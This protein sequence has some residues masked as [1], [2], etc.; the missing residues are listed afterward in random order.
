MH[1]SRRKIKKISRGIFFKIFLGIAGRIFCNESFRDTR[2]NRQD[3]K[4]S[5]ISPDPQNRPFS[6]SVC[7]S[8]T[9][10]DFRCPI[11]CISPDFLPRRRNFNPG[12]IR[13]RKKR[14]CTVFSEFPGFWVH[15]YFQPFSNRPVKAPI[16]KRSPV[17]LV[18]PFPELYSPERDFLRREWEHG[19]VPGTRQDPK[20]SPISPDPQ[21]RPFS[22]SVCSSSTQED[23]RCPIACISPDFVPR[24]RNFNP[25]HIRARK[26][27]YCTV[28]SEFPGFWVHRNFQPF[29][30]RPLK[31]PIGKRSPFYKITPF[32]YLYSPERDFLR[33]E[34]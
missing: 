19:E 14:Y 30:N 10:E 12:L 20:P 17:Y 32:P 13:A 33:R 18:T 34:M 16:G 15:R 26:K 7:C 5:P 25:G 3:P 28:F 22:R 27:R 4:P 24:R 1:G 23:F 8:S 31:A 6:R 11:A 2:G 21:N 29:S 9:Q